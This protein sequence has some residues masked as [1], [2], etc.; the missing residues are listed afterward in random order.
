MP[1]NGVWGIYGKISDKTADRLSFSM[2]H[3]I[4]EPMNM[5]GE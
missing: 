2:Y 3:I 5:G 1:F 4:K